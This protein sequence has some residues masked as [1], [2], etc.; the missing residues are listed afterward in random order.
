MEVFLLSLPLARHR[1]I[2]ARPRR[3]LSSSVVLGAAGPS[4]DRPDMAEIPTERQPFSAP[5]QRNPR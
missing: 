4:N 3:D 5:L 1:T 2:A